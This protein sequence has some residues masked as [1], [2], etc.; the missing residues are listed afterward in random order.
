MVSKWPVGPPPAFTEIGCR[1][2][3]W[4]RRL[5]SPT[6][7]LV[8]ALLI[9]TPHCGSAMLA[10]VKGSVLISVAV[11]AH[12]D[13]PRGG[14]AARECCSH[15]GARTDN[16]FLVPGLIKHSVGG[17]GHVAKR[18]AGRQEVYA[19]RKG[20]FDK[21]ICHTGIRPAS[22]LMSAIRMDERSRGRRQIKCGGETCVDISTH[23][24]AHQRNQRERCCHKAA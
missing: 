3:G 23:R 10:I 17:G 18:P 2:V 22:M 20:A 16:A 8:P 21:S 7:D 5:Q 9:V 13:D 14:A 19:M 4:R 1:E 12:S 24:R 11:H 15:P 6:F